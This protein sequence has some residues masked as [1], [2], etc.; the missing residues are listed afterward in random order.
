MSAYDF[1][2]PK[3][4]DMPTDEYVESWI[5]G[6]LCGMLIGFL[7][8]GVITGIIWL[9]TGGMDQTIISF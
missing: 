1:P 2:P 6:G 5:G 7:N 8:V 9:F 4:D 3:P